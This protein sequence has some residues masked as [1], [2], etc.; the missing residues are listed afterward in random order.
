[1]RLIIHTDGEPV[2]IEVPAGAQLADA[3]LAAGIRINL[4]CGGFGS[5]RRC[6]VVIRS[7]AFSRNGEPLSPGTTEVLSCSIRCGE[8]TAEIE[9]PAAA[10]IARSGRILQDYRMPPVAFKAAA[11]LPPVSDPPPLGLAV[12]I[13]TTTVATALVDLSNGTILGHAAMYNQQVFRAADVASRIAF[14]SDAAAV[15]T[16]QRLL[17]DQTINALINEYAAAGLATPERIVRVVMAGNTT[18][19]HLAAGLSPLGMGSVPFTPKALVFPPLPARRLGLAV[20]EQAEAILLPSSAAY[21]GADVICDLFVARLEQGPLPALLVDIGTNGEIVLATET[22]LFACATAAGPAFEGAGLSHGCR[23]EDG[24]IDHLRIG[25]D[26]DFRLDVIGG[27]APCGLCGSAVIDFLAAGRRC[28]L[29]NACGRL[30]CRKLEQSGRLAQTRNHR[31]MVNACI[32]SERSATGP[33]P[34][35]ISEEDIEQAL[36]AKAAIQ[37]GIHVLLEQCAI[38]PSALARLVIA[39]GFGHYLNLKNAAAIGLLPAIHPARIEVIGNGSL[40]GAIASLLDESLLPQFENIARRPSIVEL[41]RIPSF[42]D[43]FIES[44][45]LDAAHPASEGDPA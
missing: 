16:L 7:G 41:N 19:M 1:M 38:Q 40:A 45:L 6:A 37:A 26:L 20:N 3:I 14:C 15:T 27:G 12:D 36:K 29:L 4:S 43:H 11:A 28:G 31:G 25:P 21:I 35:T 17:I 23:A 8:G 9:I 24:A 34:I 22:G 5:C 13:G 10:R 18:M 33:N 42:Q 30:D 2:S 32:L 44:L 39:G